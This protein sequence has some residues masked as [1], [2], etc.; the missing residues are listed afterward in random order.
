M[1]LQVVTLSLICFLCFMSVIYLFFMNNNKFSE[2]TKGK[3][4]FQSEA[5]Q[6]LSQFS[7]IKFRKS[8]YLRE[9]IKLMRKNIKF[10][11]FA[12]F[13]VEFMSNRSWWMSCYLTQSSQLECI[14]G[15]SLQAK[16]SENLKVFFSCF[17]LFVLVLFW[18]SLLQTSTSFTN[19]WNLT[20]AAKP[21]A[22]PSQYLFWP[23][24]EVIFVKAH[25]ENRNSYMITLSL[26]TLLLTNM[27]YPTNWST[28]QSKEKD[29]VPSTNLNSYSSL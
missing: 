8:I 10:I 15:W 21:N 19:V 5:K 16:G 2:C 13:S 27:E 6:R 23:I 20:E 11:V 7:D 25:M 29:H 26:I 12:L 22:D 1:K 18:P 24:D 9:S 17:S 4:G 28:W 3:V 14:G